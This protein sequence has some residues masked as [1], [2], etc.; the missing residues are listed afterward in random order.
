MDKP[1]FNNY[2][3]G[4]LNWIEGDYSKKDHLNQNIK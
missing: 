1:I 4:I 3:E 2:A